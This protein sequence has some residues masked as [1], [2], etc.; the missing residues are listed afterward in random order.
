[1]SNDIDIDEPT[2]EIIRANDAKLQRLA[3]EVARTG[4]ERSVLELIE[5]S[6]R[7]EAV[8]SEVPGMEDRARH[9]EE[10]RVEIEDY[11]GIGGKS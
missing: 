4:A 9:L 7:Q 8:L 10:V 2:V 5:C 1:M 3:A 11:Y 6:K